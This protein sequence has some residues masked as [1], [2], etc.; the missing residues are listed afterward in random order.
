MHRLTTFMLVSGKYSGCRFETAAART[1]DSVM[2]TEHNT[3]IEVTDM[4]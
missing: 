3:T 2:N 1:A 4:F